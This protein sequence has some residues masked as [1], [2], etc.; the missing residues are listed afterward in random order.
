VSQSR[1]RKGKKKDSGAGESG[2]RIT[3]V[4][5][6]RGAGQEPKKEKK[7]TEAVAIKREEQGS[8]HA[9]CAK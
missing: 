2:E 9:L 6:E 8:G 1:G 4:S 7:K 5:K 3:K